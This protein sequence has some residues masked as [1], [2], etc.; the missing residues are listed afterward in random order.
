VGLVNT[1]ARL[2]ALHGSGASLKLSN[3]TPRGVVAEIRVPY[4]I[5][6]ASSAPAE[7]WA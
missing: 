2:A 5:A 3:N 4:R 7:V 1:R 6:S